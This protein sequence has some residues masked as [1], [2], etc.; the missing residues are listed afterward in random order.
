MEANEKMADTYYLACRTTYD[1]HKHTKLFSFDATLKRHAFR[2]FHF[3]SQ[4][5][6]RREQAVFVVFD[7]KHQI[8]L[9]HLLIAHKFKAQL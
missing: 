4:F 8:N 9:T 3:T 6:K 5:M 1:A 2:V 7:H